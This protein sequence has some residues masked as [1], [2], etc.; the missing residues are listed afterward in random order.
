M[1]FHEKRLRE[2]SGAR[3]RPRAATTYAVVI[4]PQ[5]AMTGRPVR[6]WPHTH[7]GHARPGSV[8]CPPAFSKP[9][10]SLPTIVKRPRNS[11]LSTRTRRPRCLECSC[12]PV[13]RFDI[14]TVRVRIHRYGTDAACGICSRKAESGPFS[15][16][17]PSQPAAGYSCPE[18]ARD[19]ACIASATPIGADTDEMIEADLLMVPSGV[20][21][22]NA[23]L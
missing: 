21:I 19:R 10:I 13:F 15:P 17:C 5:S 20:E 14:S 23:T 22:A 6:E 12:C 1:D 3:I 18:P 8:D 9:S 11:Y 2:E 7:T 16:C 4:G